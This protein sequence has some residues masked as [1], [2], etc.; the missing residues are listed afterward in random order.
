MSFNDLAPELLSNIVT[1]LRESGGQLSKYATISSAFRGAIE[2]A[3]F[4]KLTLRSNEFDDLKR[5]V[6]PDSPGRRELLSV[7]MITILLPPYEDAECAFYEREPDRT[8][9]NKSITKT[10]FTLF[11]MLSQCPKCTSARPI[12]LHIW[13]FHSP[14]DYPH[15]ATSTQD[16]WDADMG[17]RHDLFRH[18]Y[19]HSY[20][21][22]VED[23]FVKLPIVPRVTELYFRGGVDRHV[24]PA[25]AAMLA[26]KLPNLNKIGW[27][28]YDNDSRR[29]ELRSTL[30]QEFS[31]CLTALR[32]PNLRHFKLVYLNI[33]PSNEGFRNAN[34]IGA[35]GCDPLS[36]HLR[37][38][39]QTCDLVT[40]RLTGP[41]C[42]GPEFFWSA[43]QQTEL[44]TRW[45]ALKTFDVDL[46][47]VRPD[48]GWYLQRDPHAIIDPYDE[49]EDFD[50]DQADDDDT[51]SDSSGPSS[52][53]DGSEDSFF[54]EGE[55]QPEQYDYDREERRAG[56]KPVRQ[57]RTFP[58]PELETLFEAAARFAA[59]V[60]HVERFAAGFS[61]Y[62]RAGDADF[63][64]MFEAGRTEHSASKGLAQTGRSKLQWR[65]PQGWRMGPQ[66]EWLWT[67]V[68]GEH[69]LVLYEEWS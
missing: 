55:R 36:T 5:I 19:E 46:S 6:K 69:G 14:T 35:D 61:V 21:C 24:A 59:R 60:A 17:K 41:I 56:R 47:L 44:G 64:F 58:T 22:F 25:A 52:S 37:L 31:R 10:F 39:L 65:A 4:A 30:R 40:I 15:R 3:L 53:F 27:G 50:P 33:S 34:L 68:L 49:D 48:G 12:E 8:S 16:K 51:L 63:D 7:L 38:Y 29:P 11:E 67:A 9:N 42:L 26:Q 62:R 2:S 1:C 45:P 23:D 18:R 13:Q 57:F 32:T 54:E 28:L 20:L 66:L 43:T